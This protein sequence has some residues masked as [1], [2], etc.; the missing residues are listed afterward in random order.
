VPGTPE[1]LTSYD[2]DRLEDGDMTMRN[3]AV[4]L[5]AAAVALLV[6]SGPIFAHHSNAIFDAGKRV[7]I[8]GIVTEWFW[9][10]PHCLLSLDVKSADGQ[11]VRWVAETQAPPNMIP[12]GW[13][14]QSFKPGEEV[15]VTVEPARSGRPV[16]RL[17]RAVFLDGRTLLPGGSAGAAAT[18]GTP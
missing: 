15:T 16:G 4:P 2:S 12:F 17:L 5:V 6:V 7:T 10:N 14:R 11:V 1:E 8:T 18:G 9:A 3:S 13:S